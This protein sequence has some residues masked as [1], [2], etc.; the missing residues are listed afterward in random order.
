M[1]L[2][3]FLCTLSG[4][5][6]AIISRCER[7]LQNRFV[8]IGVFVLAIFVLCF[9]SSYFTFTM[10]FQD[11]VVGLPVSIF[12]SLMVTNIYLL[13][14]YTLSKNV[15]P[16]PKNKGAKVIST[17]LRLMFICFIA[18]VVSKPIEILIFA[19]PLATEIASYKQ[20]QLAKY[21]TITS[22]YFENERKQ[23]QETIDKQKAFAGDFDKPEIEKNEMLLKFKEEQ[24]KVLMNEMENLV[25]HSNYYIQSIVILNRKYP[26]CWLITLACMIIFLLPASLKNFLAEASA[27]YRSKKDIETK[28]ILEEYAE[29]KSIYSRIFQEKY[30]TSVSFRELYADA[31]FNTV[32]VKDDRVFKT[33]NELISELY[34]A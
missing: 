28:L 1:K 11:Q 26:I 30:G 34:N 16:H 13:L 2:R 24:K 33:E 10:L 17:G 23:L 3:K 14:L 15:L 4:D 8:W 20:E 19:A 29:F 18:I 9:V 31:P 7:E 27:Y 12:F 5:D 22:G 32:P 25:E 21:K 6:Y